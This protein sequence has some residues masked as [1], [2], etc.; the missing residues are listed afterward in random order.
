[1]I[2]LSDQWFAE[3]GARVAAATLDVTDNSPVQFSYVVEGLPETHPRSGSTIRYQISLSPADGSATIAETD[4]PGDVQFSLQYATAVEVASGNRSGS[5]AFL[6][7]DIRVGGD[8]AALIAR[9]H[10]LEVLSS[11]LPSPAGSGA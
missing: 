11:A 8:V 9:S 3:A 4:H 6:D 7:G 1:M 5:R 2:Y 10:E